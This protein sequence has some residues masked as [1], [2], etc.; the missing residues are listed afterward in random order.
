MTART[1]GTL[2]P[3]AETARDADGR[4]IFAAYGG[5]THNERSANAE[6]LAL[7]WNALEAFDDATVTRLAAHLAAFNGDELN[8]LL[9]DQAGPHDE[10]RGRT[11]ENG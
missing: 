8:D 10:T 9:D 1:R 4:G 3:D 11:V 6:R 7:C 2:T 5:A